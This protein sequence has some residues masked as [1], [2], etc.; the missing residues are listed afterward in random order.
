M[1]FKFLN[2]LLSEDNHKGFHLGNNQFH[3]FMGVSEAKRLIKLFSTDPSF[4]RH[5]LYFY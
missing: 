2:T 4:I 1:V 5:K 3:S